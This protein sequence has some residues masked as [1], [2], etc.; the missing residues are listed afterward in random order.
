MRRLPFRRRIA[1]NRA[2]VAFTLIELLVVIAIIA[3]LIGLLVPAVQKV[4]EAAA[5]AKCKNNLKQIGTAMHNHQSVRKALP[6][7]VADA[8]PYW[9]MG[10][11]QVSILSFIEQDNVRSNYF[12]YGVS[13]GRITTTTPTSTALL[14]CKF[15]LV[16][17]Q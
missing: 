9:G 8:T 11:W 3:I 16:V 2:R 7:G 12:D 13:G 10:N 6:P 17:P 15:R 1:L 5:N 4:R 14:G